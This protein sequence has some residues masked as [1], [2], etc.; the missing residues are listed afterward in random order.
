MYGDTP[1]KASSITSE[2]SRKSVVHVNPN[3][4]WPVTAA[5]LIGQE[6]FKAMGQ[7]G[8]HVYVSHLNTPT[9]FFVQL[10]INKQRLSKLT[11][12]LDTYCKE[13]ALPAINPTCGKYDSY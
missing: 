9:S 7:K 8:E 4:N 3:S 13:L 5:D 6:K 1:S 12:D 2:H 10:V 11:E